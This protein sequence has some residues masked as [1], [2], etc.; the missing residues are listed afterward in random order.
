MTGSVGKILVIRGGAIGDFILTLPALKALRENFPSAR[1]EV[2]GYPRIVDL[3]VA[4]GLVDRAECIEARELAFF[5]A[6]GGDLAPRLSRYFAGFDLI[7][8]YLFDPDA[9]FKTN[10]GLCSRA[11]F[12]QGPHRPDERE[13]IPA[14]RVYLKPLE[15]LAIFD[16]DEIPRLDLGCAPPGIGVMSAPQEV[17]RSESFLALHPGSGSERK[18]WHEERWLE[19]LKL[20]IARTCLKFLL[21]GGEA[22]VPRLQVL[23]DLLPIARRRVAINLPLP[24]LACQLSRC[25]GFLGHDSGISHLASAIG[26]SGVVLWGPTEMKIWSPPSSRFKIL[27]NPGGLDGL[28]VGAVFRELCEHLKI[29][30]LVD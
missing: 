27:Q 1:I 8:S 24:E 5:F 18:N 9:I 30:S 22:E 19:L 17:V 3:A 16:A 4:G 28:D 2:L 15:R 23:G 12:I 6:R 25:V 13:G 20:L 21:V 26:L 10:V 11:Q 7:I 14:G 29:I